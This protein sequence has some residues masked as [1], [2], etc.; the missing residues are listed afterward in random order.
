M[1]RTSN[2]TSPGCAWTI[3]LVLGLASCLLLLE[4]GY[5]GILFGVLTLGLIAWKGPRAIAT[6]GW[7]TGFGALLT[8]LYSRVATSCGSDPASPGNGCQPGDIVFW[9]AAAVGV[10]LLGVLG[11][12]IL[13]RRSR[14]SG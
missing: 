5:V 14:R 8:L 13:V 1:N 12:A 2:A 4:G 10:L 7:V 11:T 9:T 6:A 3:G